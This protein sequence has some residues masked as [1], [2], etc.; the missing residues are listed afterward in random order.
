MRKRAGQAPVSNRAAAKMCSQPRAFSGVSANNGSV[1]DAQGVASA[2][3]VLGAAVAELSTLSMRQL[4][5]RST[6]L[7]VAHRDGNKRQKTMNQLMEDCRFT[8]EAQQPEML[9]LCR[10]SGS[11]L[12]VFGSS[13]VPASS[14]LAAPA[15]GQ[16]VER[17]TMVSGYAGASMHT[18]ST[19]ANFN[20]EGLSGVLN[21]FGAAVTELSQMKQDQV[22]AK[23]TVLG[24]A[25]RDE[26]NKIKTVAQLKEDC[27]RALEA[28]QAMV[29][30]EGRRSG[31]ALDVGGSSFAWA[32]S[33]STAPACGR[34]GERT[35]MVPGYAGAIMTTAST[36]SNFDAQGL[37]GGGNALE[38]AVVEL[39]TE[40]VR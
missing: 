6:S 29:Q 37:A 31:S 24:V 28:Q 26:R 13:F 27:R 20:A 8:L 12:G 4:R 38:A 35:T 10:R 25:H 17:T 23:A 1:K 22:R 3:N 2:G 34:E 15:C 33:L 39:S 11:A 19:A 14:L 32:S 9:Q 21:T 40:D 36:A 16:E 7:G 18:A 30:Q 5:V